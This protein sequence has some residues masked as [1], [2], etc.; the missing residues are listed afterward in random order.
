MEMTDKHII[1]RNITFGISK[2]P[3]RHW[4]GGDMMATALIDCMSILL[5]EG[6]RFFIRSLKHYL[7]LIKDEE[8]RQEIKGYSV[9]EAFHTR[10]HLDYNK[11]M[12]D[13]GYDV[14]EMEA[15]VK[16]FLNKDQP[17]A[18]N[19]A[20]TCAIEHLTMSYSIAV[21]RNMDMFEN[22]A[23]PYRRLWVW[24]SVEELE[25]SAV[26]LNVYHEV[27]SKWPAWKRYFLRVGALNVIIYHITQI[28]FKNMAIYAK[29][30]GQKT[31]FFFKF[32]I[33]WTMYG[34]P[35]FIRKALHTIARYYLPFYRPNP[36]HY[37]KELQKGREWIGREIPE[38]AHDSVPHST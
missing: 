25:H 21:L 34:K 33:L 9:Q 36:N 24:H 26:S 18:I 3:T 14:D 5:P 8:L 11:A 32:K 37:K 20:A 7:P 15:P 29:H 17:A 19:L 31:G 38:L 2:N 4:L 22:A 23:A 35:G 10:E 28:I 6:E 12:A 1:P 16:R 30:D 13:M 27:T